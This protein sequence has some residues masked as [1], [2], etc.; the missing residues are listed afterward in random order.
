MSVTVGVATTGTDPNLRKTVESSIR[1]ASLLSGDAEVMVVVNGGN[2]AA[3]LHGIDSPMLRVRYLDRANVA[4]ARN[5][6]LDEAR[7]DTVLFVDDDCR[8]PLEWCSQLAAALSVP[9]LVAVGAPV[10]IPVSGPVSAYA[11]YLRMYDAISAGPDGPLL[12]VTTNCGLRRDRIPTSIRFDDTTAGTEDTYLSLALGKAGLP[13]RWLAEAT[14]V[15]HGFPDGIEG[16]TRRFLRNAQLGVHHYLGQGFADAAIPGALSQYRQRLEDKHQYARGFA[17]F[18]DAPV[19]TAFSVFDAI[20]GA[21]VVVGYLDQLGTDLGHPLLELDHAGLNRAWL[22]L[23]E[24]VHERTAGLSQGEWA[25]PRVDYESMMDRLGEP[26]PLLA[27]VPAALRRYASPI[28]T[29]PDG[30]VGDL[31]NHGI[32]EMT[33]NY[34]DLLGRCRRVFDELRAGVEPVT[35]PALDRLARTVGVSFKTAMDAIEISLR[36]D[37]LRLW[38]QAVNA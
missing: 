12:L 31:L 25:Y 9:D 17:E 3:G 15:V 10:D 26:E 7:Y 20:V 19:R 37:K 29:D 22:N 21:L 16:F 6:V 33:A 23:A 28:P 36:I 18:L 8:V 30:P 24:R 1:S 27:L 34:V 5:T 13:V 2:R 14:P 35:Q 38:R 32:A 11:A 4:L